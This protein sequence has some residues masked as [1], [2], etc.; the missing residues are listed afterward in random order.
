MGIGTISFQSNDKMDVFHV[1]QVLEDGIEASDEALLKVEDSQFDS[2]K[3]WITGN[4]PRIKLVNIEGDTATIT[5]W[6]KGE[7]FDRSF[8]LTIYVECELIEELQEV[9]V[10]ERIEEDESKSSDYLEPM[11]INL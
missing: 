2:D 6:F 8:V 7:E 4:V 11:E 5:A 3:A 1:A 9:V 10:D